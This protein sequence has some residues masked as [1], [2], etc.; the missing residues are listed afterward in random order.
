MY[1]RQSLAAFILGLLFFRG[2]VCPAAEGKKPNSKDDKQVVESRVQKGPRAADINFKK[3]L[4]LPFT[5]LGTL[6][7]RIDKARRTH[8]PVSLANAANELS[9]AEKVSGKTA[10]VT[11][12]ALVKEAAKLASLRKQVAELQAVLH[13]TEKVTAETELATSLKQQ[14]AI[15]RNIAKQETDS[16]RRKQNPTG[17]PRK[18]LI[19]NYSTQ[20]VDLWVNGNLA[21]QIPPGE[22]KWYVLVQKW[23]PVVLKAYGD[24]DSDNW[25]PRYVWGNFKSY[26]WNLY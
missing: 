6:G 14:I 23:N 17:T 22:S 4:G 9:V 15:S 26:T 12:S 5:S 19:N 20:N 13:V 1:L 18:I 24:S 11:S 25:G 3:Q 7:T 21:L 16:I 2:G 8:D 10:S